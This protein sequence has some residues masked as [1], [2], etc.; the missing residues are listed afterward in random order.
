[1]K[2]LFRTLALLLVAI[3]AASLTS[4][5]E[6]SNDSKYQSK[7]PQFSDITTTPTT[8][9]AG[10][11]VTF[12]AVQ[13]TYGNLLYGATYTWTFGDQTGT[14]SVVYDNDKSN[15]T[16]KT[17]A[18]TTSGTYTVQ[19]KAT[20]NVSG[21]Q[22]TAPAATTQSGFSVTYSSSSMQYDITVSKRIVVVN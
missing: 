10:D 13:S 8:V 15:P 7:F 12:T 18:P 9:T 19:L 20:Y 11:S 5:S 21:R 4:C 3:S 14:S 22:A 16:F 2:N 6:D 1:M 17:V